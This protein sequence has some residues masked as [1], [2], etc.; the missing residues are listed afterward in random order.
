MLVSGRYP[1]GARE[2]SVSALRYA[3]RHAT[4]SEN[5]LLLVVTSSAGRAATTAL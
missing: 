2:L 5:C 4:L 1:L 3:V